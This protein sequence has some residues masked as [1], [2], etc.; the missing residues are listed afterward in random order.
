MAEILIRN[1]ADLNYQGSYKM[2]PIQ[3]SVI[4]NNLEITKLLLLNGADAN[5]QDDNED[6]LPPLHFAVCEKQLE[7]V[8][9]LIEHGADVN[10]V[11]DDRTPLHF[12]STVNENREMVELLLQKGANL[13]TDK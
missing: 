9:L 3:H 4:D 7:I 2:R 13:E 5:V 10:L 8:K 6:L 1:G 12:A 11:E